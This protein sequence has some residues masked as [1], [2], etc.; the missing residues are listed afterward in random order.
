MLP[1]RSGGEIMG[2]KNMF[3][4]RRDESGVSPVV[5]VILMVAITV[6]LAAVIAAFVLG[7]SEISS[8]PQASVV[9]DNVNT[10]VTNSEYWINL[11]HKGGDTFYLNDIRFIVFDNDQLLQ[12]TID[13]VTTTSTTTFNAGDKISFLIAGASSTVQIN[14]GAN[15]TV[16]T[17]TGTIASWTACNEL[18][19]Q[20]VFKPSGNFVADL[21]AFA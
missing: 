4:L 3:K 19:I 1:A 21:S 7:Q 6:I 16:G 11:S 13:P 8:T 5:G 14:Y 12:L 20:F 10:D 18:D 15:E 17:I 2:D 9:V